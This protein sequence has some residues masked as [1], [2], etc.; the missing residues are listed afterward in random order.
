[1][2]MTGVFCVLLMG[3]AQRL[4]GCDTGR[5]THT[6]AI[7]FDAGPTWEGGR[8]TEGRAD[9]EAE[10]TEE[11]T[12]EVRSCTRGVTAAAA[13]PTTADSGGDTLIK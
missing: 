9:E 4:P 13:C 11:A 3:V 6:A 5:S 10:C 12:E 7:M 2:L 1:M 8:G